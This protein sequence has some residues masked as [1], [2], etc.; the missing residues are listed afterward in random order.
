MRLRLSILT[1]I[2]LP[3]V[4][5]IAIFSANAGVITKAVITAEIPADCLQYSGLP[6]GFGRQSLAGMVRIPA[7]SFTP[8]ST[9]GYAD[10]RPAGPVDVDAFW[11]DKTEVTNAQFAAFVEASAYVTEA[12]R[13]SGAVVFKAPEPGESI[14]YNGWW[15]YIKGA[16]W[17]HP[18]GP[19]SNLQGRANQPVVL[20]TL[21]D[22]R[23]Y[24]KWLGRELPSEA[25]WEWAALGGG[26]GEQ[27]QREPRNAQGRATANYWQGVFPY[28]NTE[29]D[30]FVQRSPV[31]CYPVNGYGLNDMIGNVWEWTLDPYLGARQAHGNGD[32]AALVTKTKPDTE[33]TVNVIKGGSFLCAKDYC[34]RYRSSARHPQ[35]T[36]LGV[37][38]VGFRTVLN[39]NP[40]QQRQKSE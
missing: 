3:I 18:E 31:A 17:R 21:R 7:G 35:E 29:E 6:E 5:G 1:G 15:H 23:T 30:G 36:N 13:E 34:V 11:I 25:Q 40:Q 22:A 39:V 33:A 26:N 32:P 8:G 38:H 10:E 14:A 28:L 37:A 16:N 27:L 19:D 20:V 2:M 24:A 12:E 9:Q 4:A